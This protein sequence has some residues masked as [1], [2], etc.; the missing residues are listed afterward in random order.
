LEYH[1]LI[2]EKVEVSIKNQINLFLPTVVNKDVTKNK[3][4]P[5]VHLVI[6]DFEEDESHNPVC[7]LSKK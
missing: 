3:P 4:C 1:N 7:D 6:F 2:N 5:N